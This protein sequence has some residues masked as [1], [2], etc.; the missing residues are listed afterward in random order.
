MAEIGELRGMATKELE[1]IKAFISR[2]HENW[3]PKF[4]E[5][6]TSFARR[7]I[8]I[9]STNK[10]QFLADETG[11]RRWLPVTVGTIDV[12]AVRAA[13]PLLWAE[14]RELFLRQG[15]AYQEAERLAD[16]IHEQYTFKDSWQGAVQRWLDTPYFEEEAPRTRSHITTTQV[17]VEALQFDQRHISRKEEMR[18]AA[19]LKDL[20]YFRRKVR[21]ENK[22]IW[23]FVP[24]WVMEREG[25]ELK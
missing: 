15:V 11:N 7:L 10:D 12:A 22:T 9:G 19:V 16:A 6:G 2:T 3:I 5:F 23:A 20:G 1:A 13:A 4:R 17:L 14:A 25:W 18:M 8:F 24:T 21:V